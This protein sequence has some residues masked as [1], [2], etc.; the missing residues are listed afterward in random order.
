MLLSVVRTENTLIVGVA[1][2]DATSSE[3]DTENIAIYLWVI[4]DRYMALLG[5]K[6]FS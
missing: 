3:A 2:P 4:H 1:E 5:C 6:G